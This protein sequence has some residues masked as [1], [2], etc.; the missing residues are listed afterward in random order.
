MRLLFGIV[1]G[2]VALTLSGCGGGNTG[3]TNGSGGLLNGQAPAGPGGTASLSPYQQQKL[4]EQANGMCSAMEGNSFLGR[5]LA[6]NGQVIAAEMNG[7]SE[8]DAI[9]F[10]KKVAGQQCPEF[11][12]GV[13]MTP[14]APR[15]GP[16]APPKSP[17]SYRQGFETGVKERVGPGVSVTDV[18][19]GDYTLLPD[20]SDVDKQEFIAG[21]LAGYAQQ[22]PT[23]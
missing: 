18:C 12:Q 23:R 13:S 1:V 16:Q 5:Q 8:V 14:S 3:A 21:C 7:L 4:N 10:V 15:G 9:A 19:G 20:T 17:N 2:V 22:H 6:F 11:L